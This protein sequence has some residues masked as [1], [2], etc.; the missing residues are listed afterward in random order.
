ME[1]PHPPVNSKMANSFVS[2]GRNIVDKKSHI[3]KDK[4]RGAN[5]TAVTTTTGGGQN[6]NGGIE[7]NQRYS[8]QSP[9]ALPQIEK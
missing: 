5:S 1:I 9:M 2:N 3:T 8:Q 4:S 6:N 7:E